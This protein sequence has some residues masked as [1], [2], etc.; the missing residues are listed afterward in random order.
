MEFFLVT[1]IIFLD[2]ISKYAAIKF[3]KGNKPFKII[4]NFLQFNYVEN[5]GAAF[6]ILEHKRM[7]F[8]LIT[9]VIIVF[10]SFYLIKKQS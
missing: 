4:D 6:G 7:F 9:I 2:Q 8:I 10:L 3:L 5:R 1:I